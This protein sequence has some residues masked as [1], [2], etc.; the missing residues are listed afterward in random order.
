M[1]LK[2]EYIYGILSALFFAAMVPIGKLAMLESSPETILIIRLTLASAILA[3]MCPLLDIHP[4]RDLKSHKSILLLSL[5]FAIDTIAFWVA[6]SELQ[7]IQFLALAWTF[8][9]IIEIINMI[10]DKRLY[11]KSMVLLAIGF[12]GAFIVNWYG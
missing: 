2:L 4:I 7:V 8:P 6:L 12:I 1:K 11:W 5:L 9:L 3:L 10:Q